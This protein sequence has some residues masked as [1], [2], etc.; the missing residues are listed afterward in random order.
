MRPELEAW[1]IVLAGSWNPTILAP[2]WIIKH[3]LEKPEGT[4]VNFEIRL[5]IA[6]EETRVMAIP[7]ERIRLIVDAARVSI[8]PL[9][10]TA[11]AVLAC[12]R[13]ARNLLTVLAH[14]PIR[15]VG[16]NL[17]YRMDDVTPELRAQVTVPPP[18]AL[19][20]H[21]LDQR[22]VVIERKL[23]FRD[24]ENAPELGFVL[25]HDTT[26]GDIVARFNFH[27]EK[28]NARKAAEVLAG[29]V[30]THERDAATVLAAFG[31]PTIPLSVE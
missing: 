22:R 10:H 20:D 1:S 16:V 28:L 3:L 13:V 6:A 26:S 14:T 19:H 8:L 9:D 29:K 15:A 18:A 11:V 12:E 31:Y 7:S 30:R 27:Y 21:G 24:R 17:A 2:A 23:A 25:D 5:A 4:E